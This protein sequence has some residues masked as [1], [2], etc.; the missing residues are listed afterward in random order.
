MNFFPCI[1]DILFL[2]L[3]NYELES[4]KQVKWF[5]SSLI[6][7]DTFIYTSFISRTQTQWRISCKLRS[8]TKYLAIIIIKWHTHGWQSGC[9][10]VSR[11]GGGCVGGVSGQ[12]V[13]L[14]SSFHLMV[15]WF[16]CSWEMHAWLLRDVSLTIVHVHNSVQSVQWVVYQFKPSTYGC[17]PTKMAVWGQNM[18]VL[19]VM[20][21]G[22]CH[23]KQSCCLT[24]W[25]C[26]SMCVCV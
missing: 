1:P 5:L 7:I 3:C 14:Q 4:V 23:F 2:P 12:G 25:S 11:T 20:Y 17:Y 10:S 22:L 21:V 15:V 19:C 9:H 26:C 16:L 13:C 18:Y 8:Y 24:P 6:I